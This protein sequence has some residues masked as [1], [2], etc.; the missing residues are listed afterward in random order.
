MV[1]IPLYQF[2]EQTSNPACYRQRFQEL[3]RDTGCTLHDPLDDLLTYSAADRRAF[4]FEHDVHPT[5]AF[6]AALA[7]SLAVPVRRVLPE[8]A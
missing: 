6:H 3:A 8:S 4:R 5:P 2:V 7:K 1:P